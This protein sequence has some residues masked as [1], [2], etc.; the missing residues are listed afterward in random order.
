[1][2]RSLPRYIQEEAFEKG[3]IP[4][5]PGDREDLLTKVGGLAA[6]SFSGSTSSL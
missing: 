6:P 2:L 3:L 1:M 4:Y 5:L